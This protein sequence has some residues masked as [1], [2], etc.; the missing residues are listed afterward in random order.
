M[1]LGVEEGQGRGVEVLM[2]QGYWTSARAGDPSTYW[3]GLRLDNN[4]SAL[5]QSAVA[6]SL[7]NM[8]SNGI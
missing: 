1:G 2:V 6:T 7:R 8:L 3:K 5:Q 4:E